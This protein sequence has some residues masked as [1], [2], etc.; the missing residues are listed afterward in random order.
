M[1][2]ITFQNL[3]RIY[4]KLAGMTGTADTEA[5]GVPHAPTSSTSSMIP[6]NKPIVRADDEDLVYKTEREK[7]TRRHQRDR[8]AHERGQPVLVGTT[9][10]EKSGGHRAHPRRRRASRTTC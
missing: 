1:A 6:T 2:T 3:F 7:F 8:R 4:K 10:V 9:S 5:A